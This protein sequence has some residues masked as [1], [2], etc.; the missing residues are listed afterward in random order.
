MSAHRPGRC[1]ILR[2]VFIKEKRAKRAAE[3][4]KQHKGKFQAT[5]PLN[6]NVLKQRTKFSCEFP[7]HYFMST[8]ELSENYREGSEKKPSGRIR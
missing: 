1:T 6:G 3:G 5:G 2:K 4:L 7:D 8:I